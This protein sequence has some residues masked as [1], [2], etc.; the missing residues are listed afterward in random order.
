MH[1][2]RHKSRND[3]NCRQDEENLL[4]A[5]EIDYLCLFCTAIEFLIAD[6]HRIKCVQDQLGYNQRSKQGNDDTEC[7]GLG[8]ALD[9]TGT[10]PEQ[11]YGC[12]Q[13]GHITI[14]DGR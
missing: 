9:G 14:N 13:S 2:H 3:D 1:A 5:Q 12:D 10:S 4:F 11:D 7:Q 6:T 8:K